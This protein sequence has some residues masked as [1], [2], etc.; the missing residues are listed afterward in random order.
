MKRLLLVSAPALIALTACE[1]KTTSFGGDDGTEAACPHTTETLAGLERMGETSAANLAAEIEGSKGRGFARLLFGL[2][3]RHVGEG[4]AVLLARRFGGLSGLLA[5]SVDEM[6]AIDG[7]GPMV[8]QS[9]RSFL[10]DSRNRR[11]LDRL[12]A[13]GVRMDAEPVEPVEVLEQTLAGQTFVITG[14]LATMRREAAK[15]AIE[16]RGGKVTGSVSAKTRA[17]VVGADPGSKLAKAEAL[18]VPTLDEAA[19][20]HLIMADR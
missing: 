11:L 1:E 17:V 16:A 15:Q 2:G 13:A 19:F 5:A 6:E 8:A 12:E 4:A 20:R 18:G 7:V 14:T 10:D 9:V 3:I